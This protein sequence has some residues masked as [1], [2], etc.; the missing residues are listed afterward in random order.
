MQP[1]YYYNLLC[2]TLP[3]QHAAFISH[4]LFPL[5]H[6]VGGCCVVCAYRHIQGL[7]AVMIPGKQNQIYICFLAGQSGSFLTSRHPPS[8]TTTLYMQLVAFIAL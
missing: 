5:T 2:F 6:P 8:S 7:R 4:S 1:N 3:L